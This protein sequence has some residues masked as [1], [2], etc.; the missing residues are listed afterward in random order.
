MR[1]E[2]GKILPP[3][4]DAVARHSPFVLLIFDIYNVGGKVGLA[5]FESASPHLVLKSHHPHKCAI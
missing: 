4:E 2:V 3:P 5:F 1:D